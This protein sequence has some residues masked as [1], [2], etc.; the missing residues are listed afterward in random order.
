MRPYTN[1]VSFREFNKSTTRKGYLPNVGKSNQSQLS[2][3]HLFRD[4]FYSKKENKEI[5]NSKNGETAPFLERS[6][7]KN[8][9]QDNIKTINLT[10]RKTNRKLQQ[11]S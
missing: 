8:Y 7:Q 10:V 4:K 2:R 5:V 1:T 3:M 9:V 11:E 6:N